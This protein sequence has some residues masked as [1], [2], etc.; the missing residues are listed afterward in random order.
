MKQKT[1]P[2]EW[3]LFRKALTEELSPEEQAVFTGWLEAA[4][5]NKVYFRKA[6]AYFQDFERSEEV[7]EPDSRKAWDAFKAYTEKRQRIIR[8]PWLR[9]AAAVAAVSFTFYFLFTQLS[10]QNTFT[11]SGPEISIEPG[12]SL[13][14]L[15]LDDGPVIYLEQQDTLINLEGSRA[16]IAID[17][18]TLAYLQGSETQEALAV[19]NKIEVPHGG[20]YMITLGDGTKVWLNSESTLEYWV[21]FDPAKREITL[22]GEAYFEVEEDTARPFIVKTPKM[23]IRV[24]GTHFNVSAYEDEDISKTTLV[25][26]RVSVSSSLDPSL[27]STLS[28][29]QQASFTD[30]GELTISKVNPDLYIAWTQGYFVFENEPLSAIFQKLSRWYDIEVSFSDREAEN[31]VFSGKLPRFKNFGVIFDMIRKVSKVEVEIE[32]KKIIL[33]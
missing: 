17:S 31:E 21:P 24:L 15:T 29:G 12:R 32:G 11:H 18:G 19:K 3:S 9:V 10:Q 1:T 30:N 25:E 26:G 7:F 33:I 13:A 2:I 6:Q 20:E 4:P 27:S 14:K 16:S 28:P 5:Q 22:S 23:N 8:L